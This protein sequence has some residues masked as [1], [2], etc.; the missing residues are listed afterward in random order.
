M[1]NYLMSKLVRIMLLRD[2][3]EAKIAKSCLIANGIEADLFF[4]NLGYMG[5]AASGGIELKVR[6]KDKEAALKLL[7]ELEKD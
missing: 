1:Y 4:D 3:Q 5:E 6:E 7:K 2:M